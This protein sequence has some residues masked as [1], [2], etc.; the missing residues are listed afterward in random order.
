M[1]Q[2]QSFYV[3]PMNLRVRSNKLAVQWELKAHTASTQAMC[4]LYYV[5]YQNII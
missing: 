1:W 4:G 3:E 2:K 5:T